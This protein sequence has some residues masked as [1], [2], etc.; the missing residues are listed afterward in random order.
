MLCRVGAAEL[1]TRAAILR[2]FDRSPIAMI[3]PARMSSRA[4]RFTGSHAATATPS[5]IQ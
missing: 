4:K 1:L 3:D 2:W 5:W